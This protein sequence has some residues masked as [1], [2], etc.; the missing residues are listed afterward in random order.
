LAE[1]RA[2]KP[3]EEMTVSNDECTIYGCCFIVSMS[4]LQLQE[5]LESHPEIVK[6]VEKE[7]AE[8]K[9]HV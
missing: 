9:F 5:Y 4:L 1:I 3:F 7:I 8:H 2:Q 6:Q